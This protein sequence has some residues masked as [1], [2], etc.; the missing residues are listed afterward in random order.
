MSKVITFSQ[1]F[2]SDHR[3]KGKPTGFV[4][5]I[6]NNLNVDVGAKEYEELVLRLNPDVPIRV[7]NRFISD[8]RNDM[9]ESIKLHTIRAGSRFQD[10]EYF[11]P[12]AW[13]DVPYKSKQIAFYSDIEIKKTYDFAVQNKLMFVNNQE[14][15]MAGHD[16]IASNDGLRL[17]DFYDWFKYPTQFHG[18]IICFTDPKY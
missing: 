8:L 10:G 11:S 16:L 9:D 3:H 15:G 5:K 17:F 7:L 2:P 18:Q 13:A 1:V 12:R 6:L 14:I 4:K